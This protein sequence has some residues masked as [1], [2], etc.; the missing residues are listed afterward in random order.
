MPRPKLADD[1]R[2]S[3]EVRVRLSGPESRALVAAA[4]R[5]KLKL[6]AYVRQVAL[7]A[8][9]EPQSAAAPAI[10]ES[11]RLADIRADLRKLTGN[12]NQ[13]LRLAHTWRYRREPS[14]KPAVEA[15]HA[16]VVKVLTDR[17]T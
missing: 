8:V 11:T 4:G 5:A 6:S 7:E 16:A 15:L 10:E 2:R 3:H 17:S 14:L 9:A 1:G 13:A 12:L